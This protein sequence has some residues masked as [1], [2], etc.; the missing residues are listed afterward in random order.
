[1]RRNAGTIRAMFDEPAVGAGIEVLADDLQAAI[2]VGLVPGH[3]ARL[4]A[5]AMVGAAF[6][7][8]VRMLDRDPPDVE[9]AVDLY[10]ALRWRAGPTRRRQR[11]V[12]PACAPASSPRC[13]AV[14]WIALAAP[15][16]SHADALV[17]IGDQQPAM[18]ANPLFVELNIPVVRY[19]APY[20]AMNS[21]VDARNADAFI[22][23]AQS[24]GAIVLVAFY[25]SRV[26]PERM[27]SARAYTRAVRKVHPGVP[28]GARVPAVERGQPRQRARAVQE[29]DPRGR[30]RTTTGP[31]AGPARAARWTGLD[32]LD[33]INMAPSLRYLK[34]FQKLA[35]P[36][37]KVWGLHNYS[38][39]NRNSSTRTRQF[40][41]ATR[42][43]V[44]LTET[45]GIVRFGSNFPGGRRGELRAA[46]ALRLMFKIANSNSRIKRLYIF[47]WTGSTPRARFDAGLTNLDGT[48]RPGYR[49]VRDYLGI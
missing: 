45:G 3:D 34:R 28:D 48:P 37:P 18:F 33:G 12:S 36:A 11:L 9:R 2:D 6:E 49:I 39:T 4:M 27:P 15:A 16:A 24:T 31:C 19:I 14:L 46:K 32:L 40:L 7:V 23:A 1:M 44:W 47:Q 10:E 20:D 5:A 21:G 38:D 43:S 17:G 22:R 8:G 25:H 30:P 41:R 26:H 29:P 35:R 42:G 13:A